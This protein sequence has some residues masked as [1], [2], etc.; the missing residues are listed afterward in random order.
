[1]EDFEDLAVLPKALPMWSVTFFRATETGESSPTMRPT[2]PFRRQIDHHIDG[3]RHGPYIAAHEEVVIDCR[4][5]RSP[6]PHR[7]G[8]G[9]R[10]R[11]NSFVPPVP[12]H[13]HPDSLPAKSA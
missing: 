3:L 2:M 10:S 7:H 6:P 8:T 11:V 12:R 5:C 1:L 4:A 13:S 9:A